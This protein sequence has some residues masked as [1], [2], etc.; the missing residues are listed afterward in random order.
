MPS[1]RAGRRVVGVYRRLM[2]IPVT[3]GQSGSSRLINPY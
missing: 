3:L 2:H 1:V